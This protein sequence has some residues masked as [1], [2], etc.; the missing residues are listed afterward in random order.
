M[1]QSVANVPPVESAVPTVVVVTLPGPLTS[2]QALAVDEQGEAREVWY[3]RTGSYP[4][5]TLT[6]DAGVEDAYAMSDGDYTTYASFPFDETE[7][8]TATLTFEAEESVVSDSVHLQVP[9]HVALP[10]RIAVYAE[11]EDGREEVLVAMRTLEQPLLYFPETRAKAFKVTFEYSQPLR[12]AEMKLLT[13]RDRAVTHSFAFLA[14]PGESYRMYFNPDRPFTYSGP[15]GREPWDA[16][17]IFTVASPEVVAN[18]TYVPADSDAD[19]VP[20]HRDNCAT[21]PNADQLDTD[22]NGRGDACDDF[23]LDG[24]AT[25]R[26]NC[27]DVPNIYQTDTDGDGVGDECDDEESRLTERNPWVPWVGMGAAASLV[28]ALFALTAYESRRRT[29]RQGEPVE[30]KAE[31]PSAEA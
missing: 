23:D 12:I 16:E 6:D 30:P 17:R 9:T 13:T 31:E 27:P 2:T 1:F 21:T 20:D 18:P 26:D 3:R 19:G 15:H 10:R 8:G 5:I 25:L 24:H 14:E 11:H 22:G 4:D 28:L 29:V 7:G